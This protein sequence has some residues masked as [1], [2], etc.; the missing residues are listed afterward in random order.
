MA[1]GEP[2]GGAGPSGR[3][4][5]PVLVGPKHVGEDG[6]GGQAAAGDEAAERDVLHV[7][8]L[9]Q[10]IAERVAVGVAGAARI[11]VVTT[12]AVTEGICL[13]AEVARVDVEAD[14]A[15]NA[16]ERKAAE[17]QRHGRAPTGR[18]RAE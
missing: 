5:R 9:L 11:V 12:D 3:L 7:V 14:P 13:A 18:A 16:D 17:R 6:S 1:H 15:A 2:N 4:S 10:R 8:G